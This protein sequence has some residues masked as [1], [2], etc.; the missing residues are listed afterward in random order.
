MVQINKYIQRLKPS[1]TLAINQ[2]V[3]ELRAKGENVFHFGFGQ[4]PFPIHSS[5]VN[6]L[7][8]NAANNHYLPTVGLEALRKTIASFL[9]IHQNI[10]V[11]SEYVYIGPGSKELLYQTILILEGTF[12]IPKGSWVSY[13]PQI[14]SKDGK[15]EILETHLKHNFKLDASV[16]QEYCVSNP[17]EQKILILN[18]PNNPTGAVYS[19]S[20]LKELAR[21]CKE[22]NIIVLSD[23]IY[24][25]INFNDNFSPSISTFYPERTIVFGG[26][27]KVF[28]A[29]GYRLGFM[30]LPK[31]L[32]FLHNTYRSLFS[33]TFSAVSSPI[34]FAA[35]EAYKMNE[36][37]QMY[38]KNCAQVLQGVSIFV[39]ERL[40]EVGVDCTTPQGAFYMIVGFN[41]F[42][43][44]INSLGINTSEELANHILKNYNAAL[45]PASE[46]YFKNEELFFRLAFVDFDGVEV[47]KAFEIN[48][49]V[50]EQFIKKHCPNIYNGIKKIIEFVDE[51]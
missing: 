23:E 3:S 51:L 43:G 10:N 48:P 31:E 22:Y 42:K 29:G 47:K 50:D 4:S 1:A 12:L 9:K 16:L 45:L 7:R 26:L 19:N 17:E 34:Q 49:F 38:V 30:F 11:N 33:E 24:S 14:N 36:D 28:S 8:E 6:A 25:Q 21:V 15:F 27:S 5:I 37:I 20:E 41:K 39:F 46:F 44:K 35:I 2:K 13:G 40:A 32:Q 18:S